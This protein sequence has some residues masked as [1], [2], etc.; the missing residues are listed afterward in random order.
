MFSR[1]EWVILLWEAW[2]SWLF[3]DP[4]ISFD[5]FLALSFNWDG[6]I[7]SKGKAVRLQNVPWSTAI[8]VLT[9]FFAR[10]HRWHI[11]SAWRSS[12]TGALDGFRHRTDILFHEYNLFCCG[13]INSNY[14]IVDLFHHHFS[15]SCDTW[16]SLKDRY[17]QRKNRSQFWLFPWP[18]FR[19][20]EWIVANGVM[21]IIV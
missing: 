15:C 1:V 5:A 7:I 2:T 10:V 14:D 9:I 11:L 3:M 19:L 4:T 16:I 20:V 13:H 17:L 12:H 8:L 21:C 18:I 6:F